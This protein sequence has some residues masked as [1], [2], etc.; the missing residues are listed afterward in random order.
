MGIKLYSQG[1]PVSV[2]DFGAKG[3]GAGK[4]KDDFALTN[5]DP[6]DG[7][8]HITIRGGNN[9]N[10]IRGEDG[11]KQAHSGVAINFINVE[12]LTISDDG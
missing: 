3:D 7:N 5:I 4:C 8:H 6:A 2:L 1:Y 11:D 9:E 12:H 10:N